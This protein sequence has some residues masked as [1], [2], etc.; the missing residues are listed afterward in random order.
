MW[1]SGFSVNRPTVF[2]G[3]FLPQK[4]LLNRELGEIPD[5]DFFAR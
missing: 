4:T 5:E 2:G 3:R 1:G